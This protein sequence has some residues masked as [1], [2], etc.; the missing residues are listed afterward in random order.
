MHAPIS[1]ELPPACWW[2]IQVMRSASTPVPL[3]EDVLA[4]LSRAPGVEIAATLPEA[5]FTVEIT[6]PQAEALHRWLRAML[7]DLSDSDHRR[8][9]CLECVA[10]VTAALRPP[11]L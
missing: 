9:T 3:P 11:E 7:D 6:R 1:L 5:R 2:F 10:R 4:A 8:H